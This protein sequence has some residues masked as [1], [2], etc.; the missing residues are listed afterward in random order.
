MSEFGFDFT[1]ADWYTFYSRQDYDKNGE[2]R[3]YWLLALGLRETCVIINPIHY[4]KGVKANE[5]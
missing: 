4:Y 1:F 5:S 2:A 3:K